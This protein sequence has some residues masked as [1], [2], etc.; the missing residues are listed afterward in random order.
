MTIYLTAEQILFNHYRLLCETGGNEWTGITCTV[1]FLRQNGITFSAK[2]SQLEKFTLR[3]A[4][5]KIKRSDIAVWLKKFS[6]M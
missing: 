3:V 4:S 5:A 2:N 1:L 6:H